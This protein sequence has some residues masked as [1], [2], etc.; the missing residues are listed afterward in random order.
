MQ[1]L[2]NTQSLMT[3]LAILQ[4]MTTCFSNISSIYEFIDVYRYIY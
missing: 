1:F 2:T 4:D 3:L